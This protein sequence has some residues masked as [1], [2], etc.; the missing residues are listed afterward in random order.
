MEGYKHVILRILRADVV[1]LLKQCA[2]C[3]DNPRK[4]PKGLSA[5]SRDFHLAEQDAPSLLD[6]NNLFHSTEVPENANPPSS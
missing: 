4:R 5:A 1:F 2:I 3:A 6:F